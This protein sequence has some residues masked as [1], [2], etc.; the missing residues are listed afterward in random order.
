MILQ[1]GTW[2]NYNFENIN[3]DSR[4][5][6]NDEIYTTTLEKQIAQLSAKNLIRNHRPFFES[7]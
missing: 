7:D 3:I 5:G 4:Q 2:S 1:A 6:R